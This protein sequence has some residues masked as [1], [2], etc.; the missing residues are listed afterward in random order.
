[1]KKK[2]TFN[3]ARVARATAAHTISQ[4]GEDKNI[5]STPRGLPQRRG[6]HGEI[7]GKPRA[8]CQ[9]PGTQSQ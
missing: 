8:I 1:M 2:L 6:T 9:L 7:Y 5:L 3:A 4:T